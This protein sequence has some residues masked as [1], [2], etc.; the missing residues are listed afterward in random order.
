MLIIVKPNVK[1]AASVSTASC[2]GGKAR[3][4]QQGARFTVILMGRK[5]LPIRLWMVS[6]S[7]LKFDLCKNTLLCF[8]KQ[9][10]L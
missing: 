6:Y 10:T 4:H 2:P 3:L 9:K 5:L 7:L 8:Y 1:T